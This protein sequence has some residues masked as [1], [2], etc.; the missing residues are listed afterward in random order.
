MKSSWVKVGAASARQLESVAMT[1]VMTP[2]DPALAEEAVPLGLHLV[3]WSEVVTVAL[4][5]CFAS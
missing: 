1:A 5:M 4:D 2:E 3:L